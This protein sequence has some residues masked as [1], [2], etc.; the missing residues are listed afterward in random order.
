MKIYI[1][2]FILGVTLGW[3]PCLSFCSPIL[4]PYIAG[5]QKGWWAGLR[6]SL[7]FS[8]ARIIPY[9]ILSL[10]SATLGQYLINRLYQTP[11]G[12]GAA[13]AAGV[14]VLLLGILIVLEKPQ[15]F[16]FCPAGKRIGADGFKEAILL[17]LLVG[18]APCIPLL[19]LLTYIA[20]NSVNF[21][22]GASLGLVFGLGTLISPLILLGP[23]AG[24]T[25]SLLLKKPLVYKIFTRICGIVLIYF[26]TGLL[27]RSW[28]LIE[29]M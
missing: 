19:G 8:L 14:F 18:F 3:G 17:G 10:I 29:T 9:V 11:L 6:T 5:T 26:G 15:P 24:Q 12:T 22:H 2:V 23:L 7:G 16:H 20:F 13:V 1:D 28:R 4:I 25:G 21:L 27:I